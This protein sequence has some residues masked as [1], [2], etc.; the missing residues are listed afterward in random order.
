MVLRCRVH[1]VQPS[2]PSRTDSYS[3]I[4]SYPAS[5][6][7]PL[8]PY[9]RS[10]PTYDDGPDIIPRFSPTQ[11]RPRS[12]FA[13]EAYPSSYTHHDTNSLSSSTPHHVYPHSHVD[14]HTSTTNSSALD[15][16][17][18]LAIALPKTSSK[19]RKSSREQE[20]NSSPP[21]ST[22]SSITRNGSAV[23]N[24]MSFASNTSST[25]AAT[26]GNSYTTPVAP[27]TV[28]QS[29][30]YG[31]QSSTGYPTY[32]YANGGSRED[33]YSY[34]NSHTH[35]A[36]AGYANT[37]GMGMDRPLPP[38]SGPGGYGHRPKSIDLVTPFGGH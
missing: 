18:E 32:G 21:K 30:S 34:G 7:P 13:S 4:S 29:P 3:S 10:F 1:D 24:Y 9:T 5:H 2:Q 8:T 12:Y 23:W 15:S 14:R 16:L 22:A 11:S 36:T 28:S 33:L 26:P 20:D 19:S 35:T 37:G 17:R 6:S 38:R 25:P 31:V 27:Y